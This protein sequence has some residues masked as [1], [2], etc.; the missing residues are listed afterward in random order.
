MTVGASLRPEAVHRSGVRP[1]SA[2]ALSSWKVVRLPSALKRFS[3][4]MLACRGQD[5]HLGSHSCCLFGAAT[6][7]AQ[8]ELLHSSG[9]AQVGRPA[10]LQEGQLSAPKS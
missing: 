8:W 10:L 5:E 7:A 2:E 6:A 9:S 1:P 3:S 4:D